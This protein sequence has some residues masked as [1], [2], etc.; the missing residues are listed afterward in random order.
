MQSPSP[1]LHQIAAVSRKVAKLHLQIAIE[2]HGTG[3][4]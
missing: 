4:V 2:A 1:I 3:Q